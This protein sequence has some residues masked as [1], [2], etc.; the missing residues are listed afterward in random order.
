[1]TDRLP[2]IPNRA[3]SSM[4]TNLRPFEGSNL[5]ARETF[6]EHSKLYSVFSYGEHFPMY[7]A[8]TV[9][10][11]DTGKH[12]THWYANVDKWSRTTSKHQGQTHPLVNYMV[13]MDTD[14][15]KHIARGGLMELVARGL[16]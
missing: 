1:M 3:A 10:D 8:E 7:V 5:F 9:K 12:E 14:R 11:P 2:R 15:M 6:T 16:T 4:V 13:P